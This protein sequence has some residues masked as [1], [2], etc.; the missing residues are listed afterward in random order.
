MRP[1]V[2]HPLRVTGIS[3]GTR[4][5]SEV[6]NARPEP[7][8]TAREGSRC[9]AFPGQRS[10]GKRDPRRGR[11]RAAKWIPQGCPERRGDAVGAGGG[12][13][14]PALCR[15][16]PARGVERAVNLRDRWRRSSPLNG[17]YGR[18]ISD[19]LG[20]RPE[21]GPAAG[22]GPRGAAAVSA[23]RM[24]CGRAGGPCPWWAAGQEGAL[25]PLRRSPHRVPLCDPR[26]SQ[27]RPGLLA[28]GGQ[29]GGGFQ[30]WPS[31][32]R[33][34]ELSVRPSRWKSVR[35]DSTDFH[36]SSHSAQKLVMCHFSFVLCLFLQGRSQTPKT[37]TDWFLV[38]LIAHTFSSVQSSRLSDSSK[39][40]FCTEPVF[41]RF[42]TR[43][44]L[45]MKPELWIGDRREPRCFHASL[46]VTIVLRLGN[47]ISPLFGYPLNQVRTDF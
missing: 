13:C 38:L 39:P 12:R 24:D 4:R 27:P 22:T 40:T 28:D 36:D 26:A 14:S 18:G 42:P 34:T 17:I 19:G 9:G 23:S 37:S 6:C 15:L 1:L 35:Q 47:P 5:G 11:C 2:A 20:E 33:G 41:H 46:S 31:E 45:E 44:R 21:A 10:E 25:P 32:G 30:P 3:S 43:G 8:R 29:R 7:L 16:S